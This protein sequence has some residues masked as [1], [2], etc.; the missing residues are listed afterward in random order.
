MHTVVTW[1]GLKLFGFIGILSVMSLP[2]PAYN[3]WWDSR[4]VYAWL[5]VVPLTV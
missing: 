4:G 1:Y 5:L 3:Y 2:N